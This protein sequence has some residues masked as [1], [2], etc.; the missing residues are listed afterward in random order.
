MIQEALDMACEQLFDEIS[1][2]VMLKRI[3]WV[4]NTTVR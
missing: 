4:G 3:Q 1:I 2:K